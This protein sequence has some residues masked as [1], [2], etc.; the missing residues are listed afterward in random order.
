MSNRV[1][2]EQLSQMPIRDIANLPVAQLAMLA[3][4]VG[5]LKAQAKKLDDWLSSAIAM[6]YESAAKLAR[7]AEGKDAGRVRFTDRYD[8]V[9]EILADLPKKVTWD[10]KKMPA[11]IDEI[12]SWDEPIDDYVQVEYKVPEAKYNNWPEW[13]KQVFQ[14]AR[15]VSTGKP[16]FEI[17]RKRAK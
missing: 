14:P 11:A 15:I 4:D 6:K 9:F 5:E 8:D 1:T 17:I 7:H 16:V 2:I 13:L 12:R 10:Q 3:D